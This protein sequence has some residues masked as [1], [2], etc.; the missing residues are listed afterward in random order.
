MRPKCGSL[1]RSKKTDKSLVRI[2]GTKREITQ[3]INI[4]NHTS[5]IDIYAMYVKRI[6]TIL[7]KKFMPQIWQFRVSGQ[8]SYKTYYENSL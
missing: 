1:G 6:I 4:R 7:W 5:D 3:I 8:I 2:F